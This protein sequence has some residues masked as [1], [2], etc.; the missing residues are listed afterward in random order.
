[1][2]KFFFKINIGTGLSMFR[3]ILDLIDRV[4]H[5]GGETPARTGKF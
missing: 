1:V 5:R 4:N 3:A 2:G